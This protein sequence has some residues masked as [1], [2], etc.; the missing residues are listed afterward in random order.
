[1]DARN[2]LAAAE[3]ERRWNEKLEEI[4]ITK[5]RLSG[6][7]GNRYSLSSEEEAQIRSMG[8][9]F[10]EVWQSDR[11]PSELKK[12]I[13]RTVIEE[14]IVHS[15]A[16]K[17]TLQF[18]IHWKGGI[19]TQLEIERPRSATQTATSMEA[20]EIIRRMAV[21]NG[22]DQIASVLNRLGYTTGKVKR[23]NQNR[24]ATARRN[25]S[26]PGQRRAPPDPERVSFNEAARLCGVSHHSIERLV[27]AG[28]LKREQAAPRAPWEIRRA[29]LDASRCVASSNGSVGQA[30]SFCRGIARKIS[31]IC[32]L[33]IK[34]MIMTGIMSE[35]SAAASG[36]RYEGC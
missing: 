1:M 30:S 5:Q 13:F 31:L 34:Q 19:H 32:S 10:D 8:E 7:N 28:L 21:R 6:L 2:R 26:I 12:M 36:P 20:L 24:V 35:G 14:I 23:W 22:D 27:E 15:D 18:T 4:E 33:K 17:K 9:S 25:H 16:N 3:L 11:C 29:D